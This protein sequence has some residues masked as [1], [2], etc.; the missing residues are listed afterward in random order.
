MIDLKLIMQG[1]RV[2]AIAP[3]IS[4]AFVTID[5][6]RINPKLREASRDGQPSLT[7]TNNEDTGVSILI[8][9]RQLAFIQPVWPSKI[10]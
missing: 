2:I 9:L 7:A 4:N 10:P 1:Q 3:I 6:Q 5:D 8:L